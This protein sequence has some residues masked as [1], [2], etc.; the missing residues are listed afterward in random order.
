VENES[1]GR[2]IVVADVRASTDLDDR[3]KPPMRQALYKVVGRASAAVDV[4]IADQHVEDRGDGLFMLL[5]PGTAP[6][7]MAGRWVER[8]Y[9]ELRMA[10]TGLERKL[11][12][13]VAMHFGPVATDDHGVSGRALDLAFRLCDSDV[14]KRTLAAAGGYDLVFV[15]SDYLYTSTI[16]P[17]GDSIEPEIF[18]SVRVRGRG[19]DEPAWVCV[20]HLPVPPADPDEDAPRPAAEEHKPERDRGAERHP[21]GAGARDGGGSRYTFNDSPISGQ[22]IFGDVHNSNLAPRFDGWRPPERGRR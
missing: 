3:Q 1:I 16:L 15:A 6:S 2:L 18:R 10:N 21:A 11:Q 5:H 19:V 7:R 20:P 8:V 9:Q 14:A 4:H 13:R 12:L 22:N 17:G